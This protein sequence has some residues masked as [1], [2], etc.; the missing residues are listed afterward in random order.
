MRRNAIPWSTDPP[1]V[2][3]E[4]GPR[5]F[6]GSPQAE[7]ILFQFLRDAPYLP[8]AIELGAATAA[9]TP[10]P[11][12]TRVADG[13]WPFP[14][15]AMLCD[16]VGLGK[17]IEAGL[18]IRQLLIS[19]RV[20]RCL[21]LAPKSVLNQWQ[22]ELYEKFA[23]KS[24]AT[25]MASFWMC[26]TSRYRCPIAARIFGM[27]AM[28]CWPAASLPSAV[29]GAKSCWLP[30]RGICWLWM[31]PIMPGA[32]ISWSVLPPQPAAGPAERSEERDKYAS[33]LL[34]TAT[35]MQINPLE[36][37]DLLTVLGMGGRWGADEDNFLGFFSEMRKPFGQ[38]D[39][40][41]VFDMVDDYLAAGGE[42]DPVFRAQVASDIGPVQWATLEELPRR[43]GERGALRSSLGRR[44]TARDRDGPTA[45]AAQ[46][47]IFRN[48]R[49]L[50]REYREKGILKEPCPPAGRRSSASDA[51]RRAGAVR[52]DR[53]IHHPLLPQ[54]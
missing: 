38:A 27:P 43:H 35:P 39:W 29:T 19:G 51:P 13:S 28:C 1:P 40:E 11:H 15:R 14:G 26:T 4:P 46:S 45:Y 20:K 18:V 31:K 37:W 44:P 34:M 42:L 48:T 2:A 16:E 50:L 10:W 32:R 17:T 25:R 33:L 53:R 6:G 5:Y 7:R 47:A 8:G 54:V 36:V 41:F 30:G 3:K 9:I 49:D 22:E 21:I 23:L 52:P 24:R 12:Q